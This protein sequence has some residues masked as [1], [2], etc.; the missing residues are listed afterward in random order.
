MRFITLVPLAI[1]LGIGA[2]QVA[3]GPLGSHCD[4]RS[5]RPAPQIYSSDSDTAAL[6]W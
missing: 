3:A 4:V 6:T 5:A 1:A 2:S